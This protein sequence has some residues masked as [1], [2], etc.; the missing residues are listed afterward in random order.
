VAEAAAA[1]ALRYAVLTSVTR[2]DLADGGARAFAETV[3][4]IRRRLPDCLVE[5][6]IPDFQ[7]S[8][9]AL[10][11]VLEAGPAVVNHNIETVPRLYSLVRSGADYERSLRLLARC[12]ESHSSIP[13]KSGLMVGLGE[14][15]EEVVEVMRDLRGAGVSILTIG[16]YL[17]PSRRHLPAQRYVGPGQFAYFGRLGLE[18]GFSHVES[19]PLVRSSYH[20][21]EAVRPLE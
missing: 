11:T 9:D 8:E 3:R 18:M 12:K 15:D 13:A 4:A 5:V 17:Q 2:D 1:L 20:A 16:Q 14:T 10:R 7:G 6:L 21:A 19:A